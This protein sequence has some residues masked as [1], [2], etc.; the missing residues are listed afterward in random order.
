MTRVAV[1]FEP[2]DPNSMSFRAVAG[3]DQA[4]GHTPGEALDALASRLSPEETETL[5]IVRSLTPDRF[6]TAEQRRRL[7]QLTNARHEAGKWTDEQQA[8]LELLI[9]AE[10][11]ASTERAEAL[12]SDLMR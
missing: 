6:F 5:V 4:M 7:E 10:I 3:R 11:R 12:A 9:D 8:Q 2:S 1:T